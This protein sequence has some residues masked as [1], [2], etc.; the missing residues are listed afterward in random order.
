M[1]NAA[2][3]CFPGE[4]VLHRCGRPPPGGGSGRSQADARRNVAATSSNGEG[5][6]ICSDR[7]SIPLRQVDTAGLHVYL[8]CVFSH[9]ESMTWSF[10]VLYNGLHSGVVKGVRHVGHD[11][12]MEAGGREF[13]L[14]GRVVKGVGLPGHDEAMEAGGRFS[15][16]SRV[17]KGVGHPGHDE[18]MEAGGRF[19]LHSRVVKGVGHLGHDEAMEAGGREFSLH[20]RVVKGVGHPG[21]DEV[22]EAGGREFDPRP[23]HYSMMSF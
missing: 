5:G 9:D 14:H 4:R 21:H 18:A 6:T 17:V 7:N 2:L 22:M 19:S 15:L 16:H 1:T 10:V 13:G 12:A 23:G 3:M 8:Y 20:G 11:E